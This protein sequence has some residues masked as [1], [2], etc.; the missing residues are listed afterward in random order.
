MASPRT[1]PSSSESVD[2]PATAQFRYTG[3]EPR[4]F[5][6]LQL[7]DGSTLL[8]EPGQVYTLPAGLTDPYFAPV[9][10]DVAPA[11]EPAPTD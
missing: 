10:K 6:F 2:A 1:H 5:P 11:P 3:E 4:V 9:V 7:P 8:A